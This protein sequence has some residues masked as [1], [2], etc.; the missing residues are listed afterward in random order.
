ML[1]RSYFLAVAKSFPLD[2]ESFTDET[3][4]RVLELLEQHFKRPRTLPDNFQ[5]LMMVFHEQRFINHI[6]GA[7]AEF[8]NLV[9]AAI[10][11]KGV[12]LF[13]CANRP[14]AII[15]NPH[16]TVVDTMSTGD[17]WEGVDVEEFIGITRPAAEES[18]T[19]TTDAEE[20]P[21]GFADGTRAKRKR[22]QAAPVKR[23]RRDS[24]TIRFHRDVVLPLQQLRPRQDPVVFLISCEF[25]MN[26]RPSSTQPLR[27][28]LT[29]LAR[30]DR[31]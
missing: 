25:K 9:S 14:V 15:L 17:N 26:K 24:T 28:R 8:I 29:R 12:A 19:Q 11:T 5:E 6:T 18:K 3:R 10:P 13:A 21:E 30:G 7:C 4:T 16:E 1:E 31:K 2:W 22:P 27:E 20:L 23:A